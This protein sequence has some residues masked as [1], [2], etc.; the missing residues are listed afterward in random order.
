[1]KLHST[2]EAA[3]YLGLSVPAIKYHIK[4]GHLKG[5]LVAKTLVFTQDELDKFKS[6]KR[7]QGRP[8]KE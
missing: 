6:T 5:Q 4:K 2:K 1:M 8:R 3:E 7:P